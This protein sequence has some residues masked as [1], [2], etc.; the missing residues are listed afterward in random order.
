MLQTQSVQLVFNE[1]ANGY[2]ETIMGSASAM[3]FLKQNIP[4]DTTVESLYLLA[5]DAAGHVVLFDE[6]SR[7][8]LASTPFEPRAMFSRLILVNASKFIVAHTH[9]S[10]NVDPSRND[11]IITK[12]IQELAH[13]FTMSFDDHFIVSHPDR[14]LSMREDNPYLWD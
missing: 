9:G 10:G 12:K 2:R 13:L 7:G 5:M 4:V 1:D 8:N 14:I 3:K 11:V 6:L